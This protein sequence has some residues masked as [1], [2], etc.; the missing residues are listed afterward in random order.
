KVMAL[1]D[2]LG[3]DD[4]VEAA[5]GDVVELRAQALDRFDEI[6]RQHQNAAFREELRRLLLEPLDARADGD[7]GFGGLAV[8]PLRP[9]RN[10]EAAMVADEP[11]PE[12]VIDQPGVAIRAAQAKAALPAQRQRRIAA[13]VEEQQ[14]LLAALDRRLDRLREPRCDVAPARRSLDAHVDGLDGGKMLAAE[15]L[16]QVQAR[17]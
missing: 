8:P 15:A 12:A 4:D 11:T 10:R 13:A 5:F 6:A 7:E 16:R 9:P 3:A 2:E 1:G 14:R 17:V